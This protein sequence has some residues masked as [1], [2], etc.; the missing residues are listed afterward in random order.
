MAKRNPAY[1]K[2]NE[3][4]DIVAVP[5][6]V[7]RAE[8]VE[9]GLMARS[10]W[11]KHGRTVKNDEIVRYRLQCKERK[12]NGKAIP[13]CGCDLFSREQTRATRKTIRNPAYAKYNKLIDHY[14]YTKDVFN[15]RPC[16]DRWLRAMAASYGERWKIIRP[17]NNSL[18]QQHETNT[19]TLYICANSPKVGQMG[20]VG[21]DID[22]GGTHGIGTR[23]GA[24]KAAALAKTL[25][26]GLHTEAST[27]GIGQH[28]Y[29]NVAYGDHGPEDTNWIKAVIVRLTKALDAYAKQ[30][31][32]DVTIIEAKGLPPKIMR[33]ANGSLNCTASTMGVYIKAPRDIASAV[34]TCIYTPEELEALAIEIE[35]RLAPV[36]DEEQPQEPGRSEKSSCGCSGG[37]NFIFTVKDFDAQY[38]HAKEIYEEYDLKAVKYSNRTGLLWADVQIS[39]MILK[40]C[41]ENP[42]KDGSFPGARIATLWRLV[43]DAGISDR[44]FDGKRLATLRDLFSDCGWIAWQDNHY[45]RGSNGV[46]GQA[47]KWGITSEFYCSLT[48]GEKK[49]PSCEEQHLELPTRQRGLRPI[50]AGYYTYYYDFAQI[51]AIITQDSLQSAA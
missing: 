40:Y 30:C 25:M 15:H 35:S 48:E 7:T 29:Y 37:S 11:P 19:A 26:P 36:R 21:F 8:A 23:E 3:L 46:A 12:V 38:R 28:A 31:G 42:N 9:L 4:I 2:Y 51:E 34:E 18:L 47:M 6:P 27:H 43:N 32:C 41:Y 16:K 33:S 20:Q 45:R 1:A 44:R 13:A 5:T 14:D 50:N 10:V 49:E 39:L 24:E 17:I 22:A